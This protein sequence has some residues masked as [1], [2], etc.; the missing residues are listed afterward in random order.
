MGYLGL[1]SRNW[2]TYF[3]ENMDVENMEK[4]INNREWGASSSM[5]A[6]GLRGTPSEVDFNLK[7]IQSDPA[8]PR[9]GKPAIYVMRRTLVHFRNEHEIL[10]STATKDD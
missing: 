4:M 8:C 7:G 3:V 6:H 2:R 9:E 5:M 1:R 10:R